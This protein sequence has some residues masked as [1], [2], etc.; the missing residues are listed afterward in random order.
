MYSEEF[1]RLALRHLE[2][3]G[4]AT[5]RQMLRL[6]GS[7]CQLFTQPETWRSK[8]SARA[9]KLP[10]PTITTDM[11]R[12]VE[13]EL[14]QMEKYHIR[15]CSCLDADYPYRLKNC[16]DAPLSFFYKGEPIFNRTR[17]LAVVGTRD[18][19]DYGR[20]ATRRILSELRGS[21]VVTVSGLAY[22]VDTEAH[23]HSI[24]ND[25]PTIAVLGNGLGR[26]YPP[27][28]TALAR[29]IVERGGAVVSEYDFQ[30]IPDRVNFPRRNRIIAG[31]ADAV[32]V[33]ETAAKGGSMITAYIAHSYNRDIFAV[34]GSIF[35]G[36]HD[37]CHELVRKN[38]AALVTSGQQL[39]EMMNWDARPAR[40]VQTSLFLNL[41]DEE[42]TV[43][44][45]LRG[46]E[47]PLDMLSEQMSGCSPS[48]IA[49]ILL[50]LELK[51]VITCKPGKMY[52]LNN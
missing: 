29:Q 49:G 3:Y 24:E 2:G 16:Q 19:S 9:R 40:P 20:D 1:Y 38:M 36:R 25:L 4:S 15:L 39:L 17:M 34:P 5:L 47:M 11:A 18:V 21:D 46:G 51:G 10:P 23:Q 50:G 37:G 43:A 8:M 52:A 42:Q 28:N 12:R 41:S 35:D 14:R 44:D 45:A 27:G 33:M 48:K 22:G 6:A 7:A 26:I 30:A 32:L 13:T 31:M